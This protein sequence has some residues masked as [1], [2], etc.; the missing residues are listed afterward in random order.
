MKELNIVY[1]VAKEKFHVSF[2]SYKTGNNLRGDNFVASKAKGMVIG[3]CVGK[4]D[5]KIPSKLY[6]ILVI[7]LFPSS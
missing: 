6:T 5:G 7:K 1:G 3:I 4:G 2:S